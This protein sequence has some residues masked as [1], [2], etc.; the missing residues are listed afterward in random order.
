[1]PALDRQ[2]HKYFR[3]FRSVLQHYHSATTGSVYF[4]LA[5]E[6]AGGSLELSEPKSQQFDLQLLGATT[7]L[8]WELEEGIVELELDGRSRRSLGGPFE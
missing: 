2:F 5:G 6:Y 7:R 8:T 3:R 1:M 4:W